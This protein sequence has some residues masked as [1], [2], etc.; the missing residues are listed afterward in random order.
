MS[1]KNQN[2]R[3]Q[4]NANPD[5]ELERV[6]ARGGDV[7]KFLASR[8]PSSKGKPRKGKKGARVGAP[9]P[10]VK[11]ALPKNNPRPLEPGEQARLERIIQ[12]RRE[13]A[14]RLLTR[15]G[16][17]EQGLIG[18]VERGSRA[19][20]IAAVSLGLSYLPEQEDKPLTPVSASDEDDFY[21]ELFNP[22]VLSRR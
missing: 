8:R 19:E 3:F 10:D 6:I 1:R 22:H 13:Q 7:K 14:E 16:V 11:R 9:T 17:V 15:D 4:K 21:L 18:K 2:N 12:D 5:R 20:Q